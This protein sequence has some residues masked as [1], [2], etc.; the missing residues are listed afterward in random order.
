MCLTGDV[1]VSCFEYFIIAADSGQYDRVQE[2]VWKRQPGGHYCACY[3]CD[4]GVN[5]GG[6][7]LCGG[8]CGQGAE[9]GDV[10][11]NKYIHKSKNMDSE[12]RNENIR[13]T[14]IKNVRRIL[15]F[16]RNN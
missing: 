4:V 12:G 2:P 9:E 10:V 8:P 5:G 16:I 6:A 7:A 15:A 14:D 1:Y 11:E 13:M 3:H